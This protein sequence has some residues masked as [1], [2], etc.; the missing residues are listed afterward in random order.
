MLSTLMGALLL[1]RAVGDGGLSRELREAA[2][3]SLP[4]GG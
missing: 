1:S 4:A 2:R 3:R